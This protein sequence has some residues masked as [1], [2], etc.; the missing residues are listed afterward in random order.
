M[1]IHFILI[2][3]VLA[4]LLSCNEK[5]SMEKKQEAAMA[6]M[7][8]K[9]ENTDTMNAHNNHSGMGNMNMDDSMA[10]MPGMDET[11]RGP[12][13][14]LTDKQ[15]QLGDIR[16]DTVK[17]Q[18]LK[19]NIV[20]TA[21][22]NVNQ[23]KVTS[24]S[25]RVSGRIERLYYKNIGDYVPQGAKL[26]DLYSEELN[27]ARQEY[28]LAIQRKNNLPG[29]IIDINQ[30]IE[31]AKNKLLLWG[32]SD[33]QIQELEKDKNASPLTSFYSKEGGNITMLDI[34][35]GDYVMEGGTVVRLADLSTLWAEAQVYS[36]Q[37]SRISRKAIAR[38][39]VPD[40]PGMEI[41][42]E[43][44]FVNP[45][46]NPDTRINLIRVTIANRQG[47]LKPGMPA[48]LFLSNNGYAGINLS[49]DAVLRDKGGASVWVQ[50]GKNT[51]ENR[52]VKTGLENNGR[53]EIISGLRYG[54]VVV[55]TGVFW[56]NSEYRFKKGTNPMSGMNM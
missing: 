42:G 9:K 35:E 44:E 15:M 3:Y 21:T 51:F 45:E 38:V 26:Y 4:L 20:L 48:Y 33:A 6:D 53:I 8:M 25:S 47:K 37:L 23:N 46:L 43:I 2:A 39:Q 56:L 5:K 13:T 52:M 17:E 54:D 50:T 28:L 18:I 29:S 16:V 7:D 30:L 19:D 49:T 32:M 27:N 10:A 40:M 31:S 24:I 22:L 11:P 36:S 41:D 12:V 14:I 34:K 1:K 55:V